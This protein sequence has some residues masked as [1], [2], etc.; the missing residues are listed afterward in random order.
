MYPGGLHPGEA[1]SASRGSLQTE[2]LYIWGFGRP[3]IIMGY[4]QQAG[5]FTPVNNFFF[6]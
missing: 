2:G 4:G 5:V 6:L 3:L 1:V